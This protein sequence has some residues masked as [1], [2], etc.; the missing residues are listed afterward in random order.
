MTEVTHA[1]F[2]QG[3]KELAE[4]YEAHPEVKLPY[5][6]VFSIFSWN[7]EEAIRDAVLCAHAFGYAEKSYSTDYFR[8]TK[9]FPG[10]ISLEFCTDRQA[11]CT[12]VV[13]GTKVEPAHTIPAQKEKFVPERV[14]E[15]V[16]WRCQPLLAGAPPSRIEEVAEEKTE[17][18]LEAEW[19]PLTDQDI[20]F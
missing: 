4:F 13:V 8:M 15:Q 20:P 3:L 6:P 16:E 7:K 10:G 5:S 17:K 19:E 1:Q 2:V 9:K 18:A 11:V 12:P 14:V